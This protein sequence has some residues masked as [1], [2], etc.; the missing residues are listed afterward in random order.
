MARFEA[1][2]SEAQKKARE[3]SKGPTQGTSAKGKG[4]ATESAVESGTADQDGNNVNEAIGSGAANDATQAA[5]KGAETADKPSAGVTTSSDSPLSPR[6]GTAPSAQSFVSRLSSQL[7]SNPSIASL[8]RTLALALSP[9][10]SNTDQAAGQRSAAT[11]GSNV[12]ESLHKLTLA[13]QGHLPQLDWAQSQQL[14]GRYLHASENFVQDLGK[15]MRDLVGD[16]VKIVPPE[17]DAAERAAESARKEGLSQAAGEETVP[18]EKEGGGVGV[19]VPVKEAEE[20]ARGSTDA[21]PAVA[22]AKREL[23]P[24]SPRRS[25]DGTPAARPEA[26][27][28]GGEYSLLRSFISSKGSRNVLAE[29]W[30]EKSCRFYRWLYV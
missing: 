4:K 3:E 24:S 5:Q 26:P 27:G 17:Q 19:A 21:S 11:G 7:A 28:L 8:Q 25:G 18:S 15:E 14:A 29:W 20:T 2:L 9:E 23:D 6:D 16:M 10:S 12:S 30:P 22:L 13:V 1:Q